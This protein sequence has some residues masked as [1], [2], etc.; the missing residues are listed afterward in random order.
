M[1][2][3]NGNIQKLIYNVILRVMVNSPSR[4][5]NFLDWQRYSFIQPVQHC[6]A[7]DNWFVRLARINA[8]FDLCQ[9]IREI[10]RGFARIARA[11][12]NMVTMD[13]SANRVT[14]DERFKCGTMRACITRANNS[15]ACLCE[16]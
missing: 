13:A 15:A 12:T 4:V 6:D 9:S 2:I 11:S 3:C 16:Q 7:F 10:L 14:R 8:C 1:I 5:Y